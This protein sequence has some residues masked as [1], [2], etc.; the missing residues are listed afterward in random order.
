MS[1]YEVELPD[2]QN[3]PNMLRG[4]TDAKEVA[5]ELENL[6]YDVLLDILAELRAALLDRAKKDYTARRVIL[7]GH[8]R[9]TALSLTT[10]LVDLGK[11]WDVCKDKMK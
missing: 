2:M 1:K 3:H 6:R 7:S 11:A 8:L 5:R 9:Q 4:F 10:V